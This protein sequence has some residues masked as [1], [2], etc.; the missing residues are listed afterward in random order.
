MVACNF[1][2]ETRFRLRQTLLDQERSIVEKRYYFFLLWAFIYL[3]AV[4]VSEKELGKEEQKKKAFN[5][6]VGFA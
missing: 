2:G 1:G 5:V 6:L 4:S 3:P